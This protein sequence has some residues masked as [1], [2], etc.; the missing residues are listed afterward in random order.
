MTWGE[1]CESEYCQNG[2]MINWLGTDDYKYCIITSYI[3]A[4]DACVVEGIY[5]DDEE[6]VKNTLI[7]KNTAYVITRIN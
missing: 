6:V 7:N 3:G 1:W 2:I 5:S 4:G